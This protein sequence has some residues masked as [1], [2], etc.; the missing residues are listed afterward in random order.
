MTG[1]G[2][3]GGVAGLV[4]GFG[5]TR[6]LG[7]SIR[8]LQV[9]IRDAAGKLGP[10][11]PEIILTDIGNFSQVHAELDQLVGIGVGIALEVMFHVWH[12]TPVM[13]LFRPEF[14]VVEDL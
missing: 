1:I 14:E 11:L 10:A 2:V 3:L 8:R 13:A 6:A 7:Q 5:L 12:G 9:R 4:L